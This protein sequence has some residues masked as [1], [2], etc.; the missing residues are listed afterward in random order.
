MN[1]LRGWI[2]GLLA[3]LAYAIA[4]TAD[5]RAIEE[6]TDESGVYE[7][8][9]AALADLRLRDAVWRRLHAEHADDAAGK[10]KH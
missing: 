7:A 6:W 5:K 9:E 8:V 3:R 10:V 4:P 1:N 2:A